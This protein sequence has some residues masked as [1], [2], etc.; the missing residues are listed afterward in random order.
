MSSRLHDLCPH[1]SLNPMVVYHKTYSLNVIITLKC[2]IHRECNIWHVKSWRFALEVEVVSPNCSVPHVNFVGFNI[3]YLGWFMQGRQG[4]IVPESPRPFHGPLHGLLLSK[5][6]G[7]I[8][9]RLVGL[10]NRLVIPCL[11]DACVNMW[12]R[13]DAHVA[14]ERTK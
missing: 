3:A 13:A 4:Q 7:P 10:W 5:L 11:Y 6:T 9:T 14:S 1:F 2:S 8:C 12:N